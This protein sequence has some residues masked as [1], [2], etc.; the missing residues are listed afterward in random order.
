MLFSRDFR[1]LQVV[2]LKMLFRKATRKRFVCLVVTFLFLMGFNTYSYVMTFIKTESLKKEV[3]DEKA[4]KFF[5]IRQRTPDDFEKFLAGNRQQLHKLGAEIVGKAFIYQNNLYIHFLAPSEL[6][7]DHAAGENDAILLLY[8]IFNMAQAA[9]DFYVEGSGAGDRTRVKGMYIDYNGIR[10]EKEIIQSRRT[11]LKRDLTD[12]ADMMLADVGDKRRDVINSLKQRITDNLKRAQGNEKSGPNLYLSRV[13]SVVPMNYLH[14]LEHLKQD[15]TTDVIDLLD[16]VKCYP[17]STI[18]T[19]KTYLNVPESYL[20]K[21]LYAD[22]DIYPRYIPLYIPDLLMPQWNWLLYQNI[23]LNDDFMNYINS[24]HF[25]GHYLFSYEKSHIIRD[26]VRNINDDIR[27]NHLRFYLTDLSMGIAFP[28]MISLFAFIHLKTEI[29]FLLMY[30]NRIR[31]ILLIF[32]MLPVSLM[33]L[34][35]CGVPAGFYLFMGTKGAPADMILQLFVT[36]LAAA[37]GFYPINRWCFSQ[38]TGDTL[39]LYALHKGR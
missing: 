23:H 30:K 28:F 12:I 35:K 18:E 37:A 5:F 4:F 9:G 16:S 26:R 25:K 32:W 17:D 14:I 7:P 21:A 34:I 6:M 3:L 10:L 36:F 27:S 2:C 8:G 22:I 19:D 33:L 31:E 13:E 20:G 24:M 29:A 1:I 39:N 11:A 38:F 15:N